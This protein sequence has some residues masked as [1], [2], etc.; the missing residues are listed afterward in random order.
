VINSHLGE[1]A[2][3]MDTAGLDFERV[4]NVLSHVQNSHR[5]QAYRPG[6]EAEVR[7][8]DFD[9]SEPAEAY[10]KLLEEGQEDMAKARSAYGLEWSVT[11]TPYGAIKGD[12]AIRRVIAPVGPH[13]SSIEVQS[14]WVVRGARLVVVNVTGFRPGLRMDWAL[15]EVYRRLD[16]LTQ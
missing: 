8:L 2:L 3:R 9:S 16:T 10:L 15:E 12:A 4:G 1:Y 6:R 7:I 13:S 11:V 5:L 14:V